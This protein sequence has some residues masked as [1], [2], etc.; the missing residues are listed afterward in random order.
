M[1]DDLPIPSDIDS[2]ILKSSIMFECGLLTPLYSEPVTMRSAILNWFGERQWT[3][4]HL[5]N[6]IEATYSPIENTDRYEDLSESEI[7]DIGESETDS[8]SWSRS[9]GKTSAEQNASNG[10]GSHADVSASQNEKI[11]DAG[12]SRTH[13]ETRDKEEAIDGATN[14]DKAVSAYNVSG[15]AP[16]DSGSA[17]TSTSAET[18]EAINYSELEARSESGSDMTSE[19]DSGNYS[20]SSSFSA[21]ASESESYQE[22]ES[23]SR[24]KK[25]DDDRSHI[26][27]RHVHGNIGVTT[28]QELI[29]QELALLEGFNIYQ[30]IALNLRHS[31]F[32]EVW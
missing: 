27:L 24:N 30:W 6:I 9:G 18:S 5:V 1:L 20:E 15:Y 19:S 25:T 23:E 10:T 22:S 8:R 21:S 16:T 28:N 3:F 12:S 17:N 14:N 11:F 26:L 32:L 13:D 31:L 7:A 2:E 4:Q 29:R